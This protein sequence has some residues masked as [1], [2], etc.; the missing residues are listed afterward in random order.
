MW[1]I[2]NERPQQSNIV[3]NESNDDI[4]R[5]KNIFT[6][7]SLKNL[8]YTFF[9]ISVVLKIIGNNKTNKVLSVSLKSVV[10]V[11]TIKLLMFLGK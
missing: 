11:V 7:T 1:K 3:T 5:T 10:Y 8:L 2:K 4:S 6:K 9:N